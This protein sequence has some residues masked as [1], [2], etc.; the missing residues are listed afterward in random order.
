MKATTTYQ[1]TKKL[2]ENCFD[3]GENENRM[4]YTFQSC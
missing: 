3:V 2:I 4:R 1:R